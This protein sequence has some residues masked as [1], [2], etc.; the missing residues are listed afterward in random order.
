MKSFKISSK[1]IIL[2]IISFCFIN[3]KNVEKINSTKDLIRVMKK[4][5][6]SAWFQHY[7]FKQKT[8]TFNDAGKQT[9]SSVWYEAVSYPYNF[10]I[11]W[12]IDKNI[13]GIYRN[14]STYYFRQDTLTNA[15]SEPAKHLLYKGGLYFIGFKETLQKLSKYGYKTHIFK[16]AKF[17]NKPVFVIGADDNQFWVDAEHFYTVKRIYTAS[18]GEKIDV[19]YENHKRVN[20]GWVEQKVTFLKNGKKMME[21][22]YFD[23]KVLDSI[24]HKA[25]DIKENYKWYL[26]YYSPN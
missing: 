13:Y 15:L 23:I 17:K 7:I 26:D 10:R 4:R 1:P 16:K 14:D 9:N 25:F 20:N 18:N 19:I 22:F 3:C 24:N 5:N 2:L 6:D 11:D 8:L 21:E 12:N